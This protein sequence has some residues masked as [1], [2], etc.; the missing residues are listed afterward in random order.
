VQYKPYVLQ[1]EALA[2][3]IQATIQEQLIKQLCDLNYTLLPNG[4]P[5]LQHG[6]LQDDDIA[7]L[8]AA[9]IKLTTAGRINA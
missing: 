4:Y 8:S 7:D 9:A 1:E 2:Q 6:K 3:N 5:K